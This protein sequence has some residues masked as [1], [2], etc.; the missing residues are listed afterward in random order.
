[1]PVHVDQLSTEVVA[2]AEAPAT[3]GGGGAMRWE[4]LARWRQLQA[5]AVRDRLRTSAEGFDD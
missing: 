5:N 2:E 3:T 4:Q 1:M